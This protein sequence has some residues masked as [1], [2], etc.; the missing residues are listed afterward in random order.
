MLFRLLVVFEYIGFLFLPFGF[1]F[2]AK[3]ICGFTDL[4]K[5]LFFPDLV[6][7][8]LANCNSLLIYFKYFTLEMSDDVFSGSYVLNSITLLVII[9]VSVQC[10][11]N[12]TAFCARREHVR[13]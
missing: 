13:S 11:L 3:L 9:D 2:A 12:V 6:K 1:V 5:C 10:Y 4:V 7:L 8:L